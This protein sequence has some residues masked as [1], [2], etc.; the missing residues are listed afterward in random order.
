MDE[1]LGRYHRVIIW[2]F[3][4]PTGD[5]FRH[6]NRHFSR[7]LGVLGKENLWLDDH[8]ANRGVLAAGDLVFAVDIASKHLGN[9]VAGVDYVLHNFAPQHPIWDGIE[10]GRFLRLQVYTSDADRYGVEWAPAR[11]YDREGRILFQPWGTDL[12]AEEFHEPIF[13]SHSREVPFIG[14]VWDDGGLGNVHAI[15]DL[16]SILFA[17]RLTFRHYVHVSD[18]ENVVAVRAARIAPAVAGA[19]Q[20]EQDYLPCR[21]F[22][23][24]SYGALAITNVPKF[25]ELF[26]DCFSGRGNIAQI[27]TEVLSLSEVEYLDLVRAQ[28]DI[29]CNYTYRESLGAIA[30]A[31]EEGRS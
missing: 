6:I 8:P 1:I 4:S 15:S 2:G 24:V 16:K 18:E 17:H 3:M 19:W 31:L 13:N 30:R 22:K 5:S 29:V 12:L 23:N 14:S 20:V 27:V 7:A 9:P 21:V 25:R 10:E 26:A 28:Q 11:R